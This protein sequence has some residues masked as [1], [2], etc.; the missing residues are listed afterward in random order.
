M[1]TMVSTLVVVVLAVISTASRSQTIDKGAEV[2]SAGKSKAKAAIYYPLK[3]GTKWHYQL[4]TSDGQKIQLTSQ[5]GGVDNVDGKD[6]A[7]LEIFANG[8]KLPQTEHLESRDDGVYRVRMNNAD[9]SPPICLIKYPV[10]PGQTWGAETTT[11]G[12][13]MKVDCS[14]GKAEEVQ[15]PAGKYQAI[16]CT[17]VATV[18]PAK[19]TTV[20]WFAEGVGIVKQRSEQGPQTVT[21]ELTKY[22]PAE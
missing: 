14:E 3:A 22:E 12:Q 10:K 11:G 8:Q 15:V 17:F 21:M 2:P 16:P 13:K 7:R 20:F 6:L 19:F 4:D 9:I 1:K 5:I 18:G